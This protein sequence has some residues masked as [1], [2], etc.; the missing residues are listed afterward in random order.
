MSTCDRYISVFNDENIRKVNLVQR[1]NKRLKKG[2]K[3][4]LLKSIPKLVIKILNIL[5]R[6]KLQMLGYLFFQKE[7]TYIHT[8]KTKFASY[9]YFLGTHII[10][11]K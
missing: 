9:Q 5:W 2:E 4:K 10:L 3:K 7:I 11:Q 6:N 8:G 1:R